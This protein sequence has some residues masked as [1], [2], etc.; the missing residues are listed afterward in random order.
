MRSALIKLGYKQT[1]DATMDGNWEQAL[2]SASYN[3]FLLKS[4]SY[5]PERKY[6]TFQQMVANDGRANSLH[7]KCA[8]PISPYINMLKNDIPGL[9]DNMGVRIKFDTCQFT[10]VESD[11]TTRFAHK[12]TLTY[13]TGGLTL[14]DTMQDYMILVYGNKTEELFSVPAKAIENTYLLKMAPGLSVFSYEMVNR[15]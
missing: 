8:F 12:F 4:Q 10:L 15:V 11:I 3:E 7:Y 9:V 14:I 1:I 5:N 13:I 2:V 6:T